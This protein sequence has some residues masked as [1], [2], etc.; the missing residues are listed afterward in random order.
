MYRKT[1]S[2][3]VVF[4]DLREKK[5]TVNVYVSLGS[6]VGEYTVCLIEQYI[7]R[8]GWCHGD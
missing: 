2:E 8:C 6:F 3:C 7:L 5:K 1:H 4:Q